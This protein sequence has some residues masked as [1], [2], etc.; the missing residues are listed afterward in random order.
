[1]AVG[2][3]LQLCLARPGLAIRIAYEDDIKPSS[4]YVDIH[5]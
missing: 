1:M 4:T 2:P 3:L 5:L